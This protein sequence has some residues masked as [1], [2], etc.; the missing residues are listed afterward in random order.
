MMLAGIV[1]SST[2]IRSKPYTST[3]GRRVA[4]AAATGLEV[5][6]SADATDEPASARSGRILF[7]YATSLITGMIEKNVFPVPVRIVRTY[8][9]YGA[10][11]LSAFGRA[12]SAVLAIWTM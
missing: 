9:T 6:P 12:R 7:A 5:I 11:K 1:M 10:T 8:E 2:S 4:V 3:S